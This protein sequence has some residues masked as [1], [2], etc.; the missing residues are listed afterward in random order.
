MF[1]KDKI[2]KLERR[3]EYLEEGEG[4]LKEDLRNRRIFE[5]EGMFHP[6]AQVSVPALPAI[7]LEELQ[8]TQQRILDYLN[9][10]L[11]TT[12]SK[13]ELFKKEK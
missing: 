8:K 6:Y 4:K 13:T 5:R 12:P 3:I 7:S 2:E 9:V 10:E 1:F 11:K